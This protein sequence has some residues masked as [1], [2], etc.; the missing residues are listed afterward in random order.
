ML[1]PS[2][3]FPEF[4]SPGPAVDIL[5]KLGILLLL[6]FLGLEFSLERLTQARRLVV[7]GGL[8]DLVINAGAGLAVGLLLVG[9]SAEAVLIA[10]LLYISSSGIITQALF[11]LRRLADDETDL[12]LGILVFE[13]LAI[14]LFLGVM[15][16]LTAGAG[17]GALE[18]SVTSLI[19]IGFVG[20][21]L[22]ASRYAHHLV[23]RVTPR[24]GREQLLLAT[25][26][27]V[28]GAGALAEHAGLSE[29]VGA[30][31]A[32]ILLSGSEVRDQME[33]QLLGLRDFAAAI[34]FFAFGLQIDLGDVDLV[35]WWLALAIP[36]ALAGK[37]IGGWIA[38][39]LTGFSRRQSLTT[40]LT[41][42]ARGEFTIILAQLAA[43]GVALDPA[44]RER[45]GAFAGM[46][47]LFTA[48]AGVLLMRES[49]RLGRTVFPRR[50][51]RGA[52]PGEGGA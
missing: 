14:A 6:F 46:V 1:G 29:A 11:D 38:G 5:A 2:E 28:I 49:K 12:V 37:V 45:I 35:G 33:E 17:V 47:V 16:A 43:A 13:D 18:I 7:V 25:L 31:L 15:V 8:I 23:D 22:L 27:V 26:A 30:L 44:F 34:F 39:R 48:A 9:P 24:L 32:G 4:I 20:A 40:G 41:L 42:I 3:P 51:A 21:F 36:V 52:A 50:P 19:V 10:G